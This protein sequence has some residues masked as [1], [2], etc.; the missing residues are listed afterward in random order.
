MKKLTNSVARRKTRV[1]TT[2]NKI[3]KTTK[4]K[5]SLSN[6]FGISSAKNALKAASQSIGQDARVY[7]GIVKKVGFKNAGNSIKSL[8]T[9]DGNAK[10]IFASLSPLASV[11]QDISKKLNFVKKKLF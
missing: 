4:L 7:G 6:T 2:L 1:N 10:G 9:I 3:Q 11:K 5:Q 8:G